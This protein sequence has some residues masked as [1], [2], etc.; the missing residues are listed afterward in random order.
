MDVMTEMFKDPDLLAVMLSKGK[1]EREKQ[2]IAKRLYEIL[3]NKGFTGTTSTVRRG[4]PAVIREGEE[5]EKAPITP[6]QF[7]VTVPKA[8]Q[9]MP[10]IN[11]SQVT[12]P[13]P[14]PT[15]QQAQ[16]Q[17]G[18]PDPNLR[19]KYA[20]LFPDDPISGMLG[21]GGITNLRS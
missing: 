3:L 9:S 6:D 1:T 10:P 18:S 19:T 2:S 5:G 14:I 21:T 11:T 16:P 17:M 12:P 15:P 20:S 7:P 8:I 13:A 4:L